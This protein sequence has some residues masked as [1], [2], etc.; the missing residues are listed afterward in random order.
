[1]VGWKKSLSYREGLSMDGIKGYRKFLPLAVVLVLLTFLAPAARAEGEWNLYF[2]LLHAHS[3]ISGSE[4]SV[5]EAFAQAEAVGLDFFAVTDLSHSLENDEEGALDADGAAISSDW[6]RG[7]AAAKEATRE[8]SFVGI[9]GFEMAWTELQKIGHMNTFATPGW[10]SRDQAGFDTLNAYLDALAAYP[11]AI[12]QF[13]HPG[14]AYGEFS[15]FTTYNPRYDA[16]VHL[17]EV[18]SEGGYNAYSYYEKALA[19]GWHLAPTNSQNNHHGNFGTESDVRTVILAKDLTE[20]SLYDA[21]RRHRVYATEDKDLSVLYHLNGHIMGSILRSIAEP[22][23][24]VSVQDP[25]DAVGTL[26]VIGRGEVLYSTE[27]TENS[28]QLAV[29]IP[30]GYPYYY[31]RILREG[32]I[33]AVTAPVWVEGGCDAGFSSLTADREV[34]TLGREVNLL[35]GLYNNNSAEVTVEALEVTADGIPLATGFSG[36]TL[37]PGETAELAVPFLWQDAGA[38]TVTASA[39]LRIGEEVFLRSVDTTLY[40]Q[41]PEMVSS[42]QIDGSHANAALGELNNLRTVAG[43]AGMEA[44][45]FTEEFPSGGKVLIIPAPG[46]VL[47]EDFPAKAA[48]FAQKGGTLIL[49]AEAGGSPELNRI[50][51]ASGTALR[52][53]EDTAVDEVNNAGTPDALRPSQFNPESPWCRNLT[54]RQFYVQNNGCTIDPGEGRWLVKNGENVLL[55]C[56]Q[57]PSGGWIFAAGSCFL[58][59]SQMPLPQN[60]WDD[61]RINLSILDA[62][63]QVKRSILPLSTIGELRTKGLGENFRVQGC[64]TAGNSCVANTFPGTIYLQD[65]TGGIAVT[66][67]PDDDIPVGQLLEVSGRLNLDGC[68]AV[69]ELIRYD[70]LGLAEERIVPQFLNNREAMDYAAHGGELLQVQGTVLT[71]QYTEDGRGVREFMIGDFRGDAATVRIEPEILSAKFGTNTL[72]SLVRPGNLIRASGLLHLNGEGKPMLRVRNCD[73]IELLPTSVADP[74]NPRTADPLLDWLFQ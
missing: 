41:P 39:R 65:E 24:Q 71:V 17:L 50:L 11:G 14:Q 68:S 70:D 73:E 26:E 57:L 49:C 29:A 4:G 25:T 56:C 45:I 36:C 7:K 5:E 30:G 8:G 34:L 22:V 72:A 18:G 54:R 52:F 67:F 38:V 3:E 47:E 15:H 6:A 53:R 59:D 63:F 43:E 74:T 51:E 69:L 35:L 32:E 1:M 62:I 23:V 12:A 66:N 40:F 10:Q 21:M 20:E 27:L 46:E 48:S 9:Y 55:A 44:D 61:P 2:G 19:E 58:S 33:I 42:I 60:Q 16:V 13:N 64:V 37:A 31:L 28:G